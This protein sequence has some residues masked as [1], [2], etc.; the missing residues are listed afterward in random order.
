MDQVMDS[1]FW[2]P[3]DYEWFDGYNG[4]E[5]VLFDDY[6][7]EYPIQLFLKLT[8]RYA[9]S[10]KVKGGFTNWCPRKIYI[11]SNTCPSTWYKDADTRT[12]DAFWRRLNAVHFINKNLY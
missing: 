4:Q 2:T 8:D 10:V 7:G 12:L 5:I 3:G 6:R 11:T 9:M 1:T